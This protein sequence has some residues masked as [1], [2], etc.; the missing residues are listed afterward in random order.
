M[1]LKG[2]LNQ[3]LMLVALEF[4]EEVPNIDGDDD[5]DDDIQYFWH[6]VLFV[7][8]S[9]INCLERFVSEMTCLSNEM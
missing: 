1:Q 3:V 8:N 9:A 5:D 4:M 6:S 2:H 7:G